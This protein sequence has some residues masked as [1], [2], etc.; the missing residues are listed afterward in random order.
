MKI[1]PVAPKVTAKQNYV[2]LSKH[3][4]ELSMFQRNRTSPLMRALPPRTLHIKHLRLVDHSFYIISYPSF[5]QNLVGWLYETAS[6][7]LSSKVKFNHYV[8]QT[9]FPAPDQ[10]GNRPKYHAPYQ[11]AQNIQDN[12]RALSSCN[13]YKILH[14]PTFFLHHPFS[15]SLFLKTLRIFAM[16]TVPPSKAS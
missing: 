1:A 5:F 15:S 9:F 3:H 14:W 4:I 8:F 6:L 7:S 11:K 13:Y 16:E 10:A 12:G 2:S